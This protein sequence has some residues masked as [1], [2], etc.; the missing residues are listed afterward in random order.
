MLK[1]EKAK[2]DSK[3]E[4]EMAAWLNEAGKDWFCGRSSV[5]RNRI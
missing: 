3:E 4:L 2:Y 5:S 1:L